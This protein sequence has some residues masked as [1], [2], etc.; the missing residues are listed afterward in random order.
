MK[1]HWPRFSALTY[2]FVPF[3]L[4][5]SFA[6]LY[7]ELAPDLV[8]FRGVY[9]IRACVLLTLPAFCLSSLCNLRTVSW[10]LY[11]YWR[12]LWLFAYLLFF[13]HF[14]YSAGAFFEW[15]VRAI[16]AKQG[17]IVATT[18]FAVALFWG[19]EVLGVWFWVNQRPTRGVYM[20]QLVIHLLV[21][22]AIVV[23]S[24]TKTSWV[25]YAGYALIGLVSICLLLRVLLGDLS[26]QSP[27]E[28]PQS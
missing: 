17:P 8:L 27:I 20:V 18:N 13:V 11:N 1:S 12:L 25:Q 5:L 3:S 7:A 9:T 28:P 16:Y 4:L 19:I 2:T 21:L 26:R 10:S 14:L 23:S 6:L 24:V 22:V 15:D